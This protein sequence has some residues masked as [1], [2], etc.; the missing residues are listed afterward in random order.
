MPAAFAANWLLYQIVLMPL[1]RRAKNQGMLEVDSI[2][3][4]F[5]LLFVIQGLMLVMFGGS[6]S[7]LFVPVGPGAYRSAPRSRSTACSR[8]C[9]RW[10]IGGALYLALTR[11]R[12]GTAI[13]AVAVNPDAAQLVGDRRRAAAALRLRA[14][15]RACRR[16]AAC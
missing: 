5:G 16:Q 12:Y 7:Q 1:V 11:T 15:R 10:S 2:L 13:R 14:R 8:S 9:S 6:V 4:T 3:G